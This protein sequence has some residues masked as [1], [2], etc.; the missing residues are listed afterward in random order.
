MNDLFERYVAVQLRRE[1]W[2]KNLEVT[3]QGGLRYCLGEWRHG[4]DCRAN[5]FRS[6]PDLIIRRAGKIV[7]VI[8]TKWKR[9]PS[10]V[11][12]A[13]AGVSQTDVYQL[14]AYARVFECDRLM[15]LY[16]N[17]PGDPSG[18]RRSFGLANGRE[19]LTIATLGLSA[20]SETVKRELG[21]L[22]EK[23]MS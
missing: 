19:R 9:L 6:K 3:A 21:E 7:A 20:G 10:D 2:P 4:I 13:K 17:V 5:V 23:L 16:P 22:A 1:L 18:I 12:D 11:L 14:M 8:D 15:L